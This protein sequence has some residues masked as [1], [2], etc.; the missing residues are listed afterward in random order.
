MFHK[1]ILRRFAPPVDPSATSPSAPSP[2]LVPRVLNPGNNAKDK[3][4][5]ET[6]KVEGSEV[7][8]SWSNDVLESHIVFSTKVESMDEWDLV[9]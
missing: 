3:E 8:V 6:E 7:F 9:K 2:A 1:S 5:S 4:T